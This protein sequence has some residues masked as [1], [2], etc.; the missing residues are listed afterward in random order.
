MK[1]NNLL[2]KYLLRIYSDTFFPIFSTLFVITSIIYLVRISTLT[3]VM[4]INF[5]ELLELYA[6]IIPTILFYTFPI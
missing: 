2:K 6:Y 4:Q 3:S 5:L 1:R